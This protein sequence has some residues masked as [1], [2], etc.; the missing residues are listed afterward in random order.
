M[1]AYNLFTAPAQRSTNLMVDGYY[2]GR[3]RQANNKWVFDGNKYDLQ[4]LAEWFGE[5][6]ESIVRESSIHKQAIS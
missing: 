3:L 4:E 2:Y 1:A 5:Q 6:A